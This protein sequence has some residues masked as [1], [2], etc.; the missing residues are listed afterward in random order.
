[1]KLHSFRLIASLLVS[2]LSVWMVSVSHAQ[3]PKPVAKPIPVILDSDIGDDI[4][5][6]WALGFLLRCPELNLKLVVGDYGR[7]QYRARLFAKFLQT[8]GRTDVP[9][10]V[11]LDIEPVGEGQQSEWVK[12]Y[13]LKSYPGKVHP[14]GVQT[15]I[16]TIMQ[17][18]EPITLIAVGPLPNIAE[19][20][21][22]E[23]RI[24]EKAR[25]VGMHGSV[26]RGYGGSKTIHAEWNVKADAKSCQAAFTAPWEMVITPLDTCGLVTLDGERYRRVR[27]AKSPLATAIVEN[28]R[29]WS[30]KGKQAKEVAEQRSS[31]LFD[32]VAVYLAFSQDLCK[33][34]SVGLRVTD[35]GFTRVDPQ[36]KKVAAAID[37]KNL[38]AYRDLLVERI[39]REGR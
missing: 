26:Y 22:R 10:G 37:W 20:L 36:A 24:A 35:D 27:D 28:Y 3:S 6:T 2:A 1:M 32:T 15:L 9:I 21:K 14:D 29:A 34:E 13:E 8:V 39:T 18:K 7:A 16:D 17:S 19:A 25:F 5:D 11:G 30:L 33:M 23:P 38:D 4:D 12:G 31:V